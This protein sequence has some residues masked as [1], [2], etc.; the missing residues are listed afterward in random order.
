M[1]E[2]KTGRLGEGGQVT[3]KCLE[4]KACAV[5]LKFRCGEG[6]ESGMRSFALSTMLAVYRAWMGGVTAG[7]PCLPILAE[8]Q[9]ALTQGRTV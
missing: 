7:K 2:V 3:N 8:E 6:G 5:V 1:L 9:S 4:R